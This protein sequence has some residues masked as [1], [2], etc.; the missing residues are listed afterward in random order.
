MDI[1]SAQ[2]TLVSSLILLLCIS[3]TNASEKK[4]GI[5]SLTNFHKMKMINYIFHQTR[6]YS[7]LL[8]L[9]FLH[10][11]GVPALS[12]A[13]DDRQILPENFA[14]KAFHHI[15][16]LVNEGPRPAGSENEMKAA[17][18]IWKQFKEIG[19]ESHIE[20]FEYD[21]YEIL[22]MDL[23]IGNNHFIPLGLGF[24]PYQNKSHYQGDA[25]FI[26]LDDPTIDYS[27]EAI[28][29]KTII[30]NKFAKHFQL[31]R[32]QPSLIIYLNNKD[33]GNLRN[34]KEA[35]FDLK[36][37]GQFR[38]FSS[39]NVIAKLAISNTKSSEI[40]IGAHLDS[41]RDSPGAS[42]NGSG[43]ATMIELARYFKGIEN[44]LSGNI[45]FIAF[46]AE[47]IGIL[48]SRI[49]TNSHKESVRQCALYL[50]IDDVGGDGL[51]S[52]QT[53]GGVSAPPLQLEDSLSNILALQPWEGT[54]SFWRL[55]PEE[56]LLGFATTV[57][58]P[59]WLADIISDALEESGYS[60]RKVGN[61][62]A[63]DLSFSYNGVP[64]TSISI[65]GKAAHTPDD[66]LN[67]ISKSSLYK[68]GDISTRIIIKTINLL[69]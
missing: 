69:K 5:D 48:G 57:N 14:D 24:T 68:A 21:T 59:E 38:K 11:F 49:Y 62:G 37:V 31:F 28:A 6:L 55:L 19:L 56:Y 26:D 10:L 46:G 7:K 42:D 44:S 36:I 52:I 4:I 17:E 41:Y 50:N 39:P 2:K 13:L 29:G 8:L 25:V 43:V 34:A 18:Y 58:H 63:D 61:S 65:Q 12:Q 54:T 9:L 27:T 67:V 53:L 64:S 47:E 66:D 45:R 23:Q 15:E 35:M 51:G 16:M 22:S 60:L 20:I 33:F 32:F 40:I 3:M 30:S 1:H